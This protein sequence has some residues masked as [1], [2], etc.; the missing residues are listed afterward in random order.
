MRDPVPVRV[1]R[2]RQLAGR[3]AAIT[4]S[5]RD[6]RAAQE[7][8][9]SLHDVW[10][11]VRHRLKVPRGK[12]KAEAFMEWVSDHPEKVQAI[13]LATSQGFDREIEHLQRHCSRAVEQARKSLKRQKFDTFAQIDEETA[14]KLQ[15]CAKTLGPAYNPE[16]VEMNIRLTETGA[17][18]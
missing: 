7:I 3:K 10:L 6:E 4:R 16:A 2:A 15:G 5:E 18:F 12:R 14:G 9:A 11:K 8:P 13:R 1:N 17:P